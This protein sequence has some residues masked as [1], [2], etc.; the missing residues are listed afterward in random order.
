MAM[1]VERSCAGDSGH[2]TAA[3]FFDISSDVSDVERDCSESS[4]VADI[5]TSVFVGLGVRVSPE[6]S[7]LPSS[8]FLRQ[9]MDALKSFV[10]NTSTRR[11][12]IIES[13]PGI[14]IMGVGR[15][16]VLQFFVRSLES[17]SPHQAAKRHQTTIC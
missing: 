13:T 7:I 2:G 16:L 12:P 3:E 11:C 5:C 10:L 6:T 4:R 1:Q 8:C 17:K 14:A 15:G 9:H